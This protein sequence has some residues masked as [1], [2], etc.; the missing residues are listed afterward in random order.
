MDASRLFLDGAD[1]E[2]E[3]AVG[4]VNNGYTY[5]ERKYRLRPPFVEYGTADQ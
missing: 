4:E 5:D 2:A 1:R 3:G